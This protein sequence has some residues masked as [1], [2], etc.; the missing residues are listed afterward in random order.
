[1]NFTST[2][3]ILTLHTGA[4]CQMCDPIAQLQYTNSSIVV[5]HAAFVT[6]GY[7]SATPRVFFTTTNKIGDYSPE[8]NIDHAVQEKVHSK[9]QSLQ[10]ITHSQCQGVTGKDVCVIFISVSERGFKECHDFCWGDEKD[11]EDNDDAQCEGE[12]VWRTR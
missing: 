6:A 3:A 12:D 2:Y 8:V 9:V 1:M 7:L 10:I 4:Q 11:V 5:E